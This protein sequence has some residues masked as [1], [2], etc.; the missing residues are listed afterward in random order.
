MREKDECVYEN[1]RSEL[2]NVYHLIP[3]Y[4]FP[5]PT[6]SNTHR[7]TQRN[8]WTSVS[9]LGLAAD[10]LVANPTTKPELIPYLAV[11]ESVYQ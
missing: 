2:D 11:L 8:S 9:M 10:K 6:V 5:T 4:S 1:S 3:T 7:H